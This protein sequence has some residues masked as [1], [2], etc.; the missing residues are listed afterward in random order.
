[1][2]DITARINVSWRIDVYFCSRYLYNINSWFEI[3]SGQHKDNNIGICSFLT[4]HISLRRKS[5]DFDLNIIEGSILVGSNWSR[6]NAMTIYF[7]TV[8]GWVSLLTYSPRMRQIVG[9]CPCRVKANT[10]QLVFAASPLGGHYLE[11][12]KTG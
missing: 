3:R 4:R 1:M 2:K 7:N 6:P 12:A 8:Y 9:S 11:R 10:I 5:R